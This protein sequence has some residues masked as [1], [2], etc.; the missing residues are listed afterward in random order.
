MGDKLGQAI[1]LPHEYEWEV[2]ARW[3][4][5]KADG[6]TYPWGD[7]FDPQKANTHEGGIRQT[8]AVGLYPAGKNEALDL[9]D[10]SG[11]VWEWCR[12]K[13]DNPYDDAVEQSGDWRVLRGGAWINLQESARVANRNEDLNDRS[14]R[15]YGFRVVVVRRS[16]F[17][18]VL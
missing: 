18:Q 17:H 10:L 13:Y 1:E 9:Y 12:N 11:N 2:A 7:E 5:E 14:N 4:G 16:P 6:R 3:D 8:T 15:D